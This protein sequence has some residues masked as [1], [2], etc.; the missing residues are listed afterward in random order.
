MLICGCLSK[1]GAD[2]QM[3]ENLP[4]PEE[5]RVTQAEK[6]KRLQDQLKASSVLFGF[7]ILGGRLLLCLCTLLPI[8]DGSCLGLD[9]RLYS[10][11]ENH[12]YCSV[13]AFHFCSFAS[14]FMVFLFLTLVSP[15]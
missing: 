8:L 13:V 12:V 14:M 6:N 3:E 4:R 9:L 2:L 1:V 15:L 10:S 11:L 5:D 7:V